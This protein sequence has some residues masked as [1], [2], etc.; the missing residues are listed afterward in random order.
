[1]L[2]TDWLLRFKSAL[3]RVSSSKT[4]GAFKKK[5]TKNKQSKKLATVTF[6][7]NMIS[8]C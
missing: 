5:Q 3:M 2:V 7:N 6:S 8:L 4:C 1:M